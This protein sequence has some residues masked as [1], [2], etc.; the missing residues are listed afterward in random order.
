MITIRPARLDDLDALVELLK[1]LFSIEA[2]FAVNDR[3]QR[4][5]LWMLLENGMGCLL[6]AECDHDVVGMVSGQLTVST[7]E[8]GPAL[9]VEDMVVNE[10]Y[11]GRGIGRRLLEA[12]SQWA[13]AHH[14]TRLQL[15]AD[16]TNEPALAFYRHLGWH[17]TQLICLRKYESEV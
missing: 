10:G 7:A 17:S 1:L 3:L 8:G 12:I 16:R 2:D 15:L 14:V 11:R 9:L 5:G 13:K 6:V 4:R